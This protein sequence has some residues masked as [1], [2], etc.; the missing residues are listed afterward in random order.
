M[1]ATENRQANNQQAHNQ[2]FEELLTQNQ[3]ILL[4]GATGT[5]LQTQGLPAG[6]RPERWNLTH[7]EKIRQLHEAYLRAGSQIIYSN[8]FGSS[9][10]KLADTD[11]NSAEIITAAVTIAKEARDRVNPSAL[12]AFSCG[13]LGELLEPSG[14][15]TFDEAYDDFTQQVTLAK[16]AGADL[17]VFETMTD[18]YELKA[19]LL[20]ACE[21]STLPVI[22][23]M[24]FEPDGRTFG[25]TDVASFAALAE[26]L[27][28][29]ALGINCSAGPTDLAPVV[30]QLLAVSELPVL[31]KP[32]AGLP[33]PTTGRYSLTEEDFVRAFE[34]LLA[35][36]LRLI[37]GCCGTTPDF[38]AALAE[39]RNHKLVAAPS[40][41]TSDHSSAPTSEAPSAPADPPA[42]T[43]NA[44]TTT[45][46]ICSATRT[47]E[48]GAKP[49]FVGESLN[50]TGRKRLKQAL[51]DRDYSAYQASASAQEQA[52]ADILDL[53][54]GLPGIDEVQAMKAAVIA[55]QAVTSLP[56]QL[57]SNKPSV[58]EAGLRYCNGKPLINS[59]NAKEQ[60]M[61]QVLPLAAKY[62]AALI[63][64]PIDEN[65]IP[66]TAAGRIQVLE[67]LIARALS[68]GIKRSNLI[69][70]ALVM[71]AS[72]E[73]EGAAVTLETIRL[74]K[75]QLRLPV[76]IGLSNVSF[77]LPNRP[78]LN[79]VFYA[80][81]LASGLDLAILN[82]EIPE[83][84]EIRA[85]HMAL[86]NMDPG[87]KNYLA[88]QAA[89]PTTAQSTTA[90]AATSQPATTQSS[91]TTQ[92]TST[93]QAAPTTLTLYDAVLRGLDKE[94]REAAKAQLTSKE[95]LD[96]INETLIPALDTVGSR[97][98]AGTFFLPQL[99]QSAKAAEAAFAPLRQAIK[100]R[101]GDTREAG[102]ILLATVQ[103][104]IHD[105]GKNIAKTLLE[106]YGYRI[107]DLGK[108]VP[109]Q[110]I[111]E[112]AL[113][114]NIH[115]VGL[116]ALMTS[117]LPAMEETI[118][119][120]HEAL[121]SC[122]IM[123]GG[124]VLTPDYARQIGAD[125]YCPDAV[126]GVAA[127]KE[128]FS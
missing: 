54:C 56:I 92:A 114:E 57:D 121:P 65:G 3:P 107:I 37:G 60:E 122:K 20:A 49:L 62:G 74:T 68:Y 19:A 69:C 97:F 125:Y 103:G 87:Q 22:A 73:P 21:N 102:V 76:L 111:V 109:P 124:A 5:V 53:N 9:A 58:L 35:K 85:A 84:H 12:I 101:G 96:I 95:P 59:C 45:T 105:I 119:L 6:E 64:L 82:P 127:A 75:Q 94:A 108:D 8:T 78:L 126:S 51:K 83:Y 118:R 44:S 93:T 14:S 24:S 81:A 110:T 23:S 79:R 104:D 99:L 40:E 28:A 72:A 86:H 48:I 66:P 117:T 55:V 27:H 7:P 116:S 17:I 31:F 2:R 10:H 128:V 100:S 91:S 15:L 90:Q 113:A 80:Q 26:S 39:L 123:C 61:T 50:P 106:N 70:D 47:V 13:P 38:I 46:T 77:G 34:P 63:L 43:S 52:G 115:L 71:T 4:D 32:N 18:L 11:L 30:E 88:M 67:K 36:S 33:D 41:P 29:A 89:Q 112:R 1:D 16:A 98:A 120:L 25:G 42:T